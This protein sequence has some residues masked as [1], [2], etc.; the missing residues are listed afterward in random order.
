MTGAKGEY[1]MQKII[2]GDNVKVMLG[3]DAGKT[4]AVEKVLG[5][6]GKVYVGGVNLYKR[7]VRSMQGVEGGIIDLPKPIN[8]SNVQLVC[9]A[10]K[11]VT[12]VGFKVEGET[13]VRV[14]RKCGKAVG[15]KKGDK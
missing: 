9:P 13:K 1:I 4:G 7:H 8:V 12:R 11:K 3:K 2:K 5:K 14:C 15:N 10:C 6:S